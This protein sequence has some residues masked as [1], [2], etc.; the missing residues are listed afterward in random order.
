MY[1]TLI[2]FFCISWFIAGKSAYSKNVSFESLSAG[3]D[4]LHSLAQVK[5]R[6]IHF[7]LGGSGNGTY[8]K[9]A[10]QE[11]DSWLRQEL[12]GPFIPVCG[13]S[14]ALTLNVRLNTLARALRQMAL[15]YRASGSRYEK[16]AA[17]RDRIING[18]ENILHYFNP[19][20]ARPGNW[21][22]WLITLPDNL[23]ATALLMGP[24][25]PDDLLAKLKRTLSHELTEKLILTGSNA[26]AEARNHIYL[27]L[28][29]TDPGR[30]KRGS[31]YVFRTVRFGTQQGVREDYCYLY[32]GHIPYAGGYG[33]GFA[34]TIAE[35][36]YLFDGTPWAIEHNHRNLVM[37]LLLDHTRWFISGGKMDLLARGRGYARQS[38]APAVLS[39][40]LIMARVKGSGNEEAAQTAMAMLEEDPR[41]NLDL[42]I[43]GLADQLSGLKGASPEG[44]RYWPSGEI[45]AFN[46][47][48][49][50]VGLRQ[51]SSRVQDYEYLMRADGGE[52]GKGWNLAFGFTNIMRTDGAGS[53]Y[54]TASGRMLSGIDMEYLPGTTTRIGSNPENPLFVY[55]PHKQTM[56]TT[57]YS[58]N[59]GK[60]PF[61]GGAGGKDGGMAGFELIPPYG[62]FSAQKSV[63][64][65]PGGFWALG[66]GITARAQHAG[67]R[68]PVQTT[69]LQWACK[70][71][72]PAVVVDDKTLT[73][74]GDTTTVL[75][76]VRWFWLQHE[77]VAVV[78]DQPARICVRLKDHILTVW[79]NHGAH[80]VAAGYAYAVLPDITLPA[81]RDFAA[82]APVRPSRCDE[83]VHAVRNEAD[84]SNGIVFFAPDT[85]MGIASQSPLIIYRQAQRD[86]G[87]LTMQ[88]PLHGK[89]RIRFSIRDINGPFK[90]MDAAIR[91][92]PSA[93]G[94]TQVDVSTALG[95][96]YRLGYGAQASKLTRVPRKDLDLSCY[97]D[98]RVE[99]TS[100]LQ[101]T[102][103]TVHL[104]EEAIRDDYRLSVHFVKSQRLY[105]FSEKDIIDRPAPNTVRYRWL[106]KPADGPPVFSGYLK[107]NHGQFTV[108]LVTPW[109]EATD[110]FTVPEFTGERSGTISG[111]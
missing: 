98:F 78:F 1:R 73:F 83:K 39:G 25:L 16:N 107:A 74:P 49:F 6:L 106:R 109:I 46:Q 91:V 35:F 29:E 9:K 57:G 32:H 41:R 54:D 59:F 45:G 12:S 13:D 94:E 52:G 21:H 2:C 84:G 111:R 34:K 97:Q 61:A 3:T 37:D 7:W 30:L 36:I 8:R 86:G 79:L 47:P 10:L 104:P 92:T 14:A 60:S 23:G 11:N 33:A 31:E 96:I 108:Y 93:F 101:E 43:G 63:F 58:L 26:A 88:D 55:D 70:E 42:A 77:N 68:Q 40:L 24:A 56:S 95:R 80:P 38:D 27:A 18:I 85:C 15:A 72:R 69:I 81:T 90:E 19:S 65:F 100:N 4:S 5:Q 99:A 71:S 103:L 66:S 64:F 17:V 50:H 62:D 76:R 20:T 87:I 75:D 105:D 102:I 67:N 53:W 44:F 82:N 48:A 22:E 51:Y 110:S 28:L 89:T